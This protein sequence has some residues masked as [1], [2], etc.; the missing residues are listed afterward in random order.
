MDSDEGRIAGNIVEAY[1][2]K[3]SDGLNK[4][5]RSTNVSFLD[6]EVAKMAMGIQVV[7]GGAS[8]VEDFT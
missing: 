3:D 2:S 7:G 1:E 4:L 8:E 6:N 5:M